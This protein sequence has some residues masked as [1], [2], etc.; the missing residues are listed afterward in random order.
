MES[1]TGSGVSLAPPA[2]ARLVP[3]VTGLSRLDSAVTG[4][5]VPGLGH[6]WTQP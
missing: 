3:A 1:E 2:G 4:L 5:A 6:D